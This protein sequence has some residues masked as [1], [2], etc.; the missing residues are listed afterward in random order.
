MSAK[1]LMLPGRAADGDEDVADEVV[2][3]APFLLPR[4]GMCSLLS[5]PRV[6]ARV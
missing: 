4:N 3:D 6:E 2:D 1:E 5:P